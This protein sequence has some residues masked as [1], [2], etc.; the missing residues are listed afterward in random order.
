MSK[1]MFLLL[2]LSLWAGTAVAQTTGL[3]FTE[4]V[5]GSGN[6]KALEIFNGTEDVINLGGYTVERYSNG[7]VTSV[8]IALNAVDLG[9]GDVFVIANP[10]ADAGL[11]ALADQTDTDISFNGDDALVLAFGGG[12][13][14]DSIGQVGVDPGSA[15][16]CPDGSTVNHTMRRLSSVCDGDHVAD[17]AFDPCDQ[18]LFVPIDV[19]SGLGSHIADCGAVADHATGWG[20]FKAQYRR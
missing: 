10:L 3:M 15:W 8:S 13:I 2:G 18:W 20:T 7:A 16:A 11:L 12:T 6:N 9:P 5:E 17:D 4:Y 1:I 19:F 14:V